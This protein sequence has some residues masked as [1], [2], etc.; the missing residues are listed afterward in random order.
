M[1][2]HVFQNETIKQQYA[3]TGSKAKQNSP[4]HS[5]KPAAANGALGNFLL[6]MEMEQHQRLVDVRDRKK[7]GEVF[8]WA[9]RRPDDVGVVIASTDEREHKVKFNTLPAV[10]HEETQQMLRSLKQDHRRPEE[11]DD[12]RP[13]KLIQEIAREHVRGAEMGLD[14]QQVA[15]HIAIHQARQ[16]QATQREAEVANACAAEICNRPSPKKRTFD[17]RV[18]DDIEPAEAAKE[19]PFHAAHH[20][21]DD[22]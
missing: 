12:S 15:K 22:Y 19:K 8:R 10:D 1:E 21:F 18:I 7:D 17:N 2:R 6:N 3:P 20:N 4:T 13:Q 11:Q 14:E 5:L 16:T 9:D